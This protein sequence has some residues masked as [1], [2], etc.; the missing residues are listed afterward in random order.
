[1]QRWGKPQEGLESRGRH[2]SH[3]QVAQWGPEPAGRGGIRL[4][5]APWIPWTEPHLLTMLPLLALFLLIGPSV[6]TTAGDREE[7][8]FGAEAES[9]VTVNLKVPFRDDRGLGDSV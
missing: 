8:A 2:P 5:G 7:L 3:I 9:W 1:M 4:S 6:C